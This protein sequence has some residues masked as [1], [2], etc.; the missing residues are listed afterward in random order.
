MGLYL[1]IVAYRS[2]VA[3]VLS[4]IWQLELEPDYLMEAF[5]QALI[6]LAP[7]PGSWASRGDLCNLT[8]AYGFPMQFPDPRWTSMA[9]K[10]RVVS[11]VAS[12]CRE[13]RRELEYLPLE[14]GRRPFPSWYA[15]SYFKVLADTLDKAEQAGIS[16]RFI[17]KEVATSKSKPSFQG[18]AERLINTKFADV[19]FRDSR[20]R[21]KC[22]TWRFD[23]LP[24]RL[25]SRFMR[26][27][28]V[29]LEHCP[30]RVW[31]VFFRTIW[32][33]WVTHER[34]KALLPA[35]PCLLGC[36]WPDDGLGHYVC[37][38]VY[39]QFLC[40]D[41]PRGLGIRGLRRTK[42]NAMLLCC[43]LDDED[44]VRLA[45]GLYALHRTVNALR[46]G[47]DGALKDPTILLRMFAKH[48]VDFSTGSKLLRVG[49]LAERW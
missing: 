41:R 1:N 18:V 45:V 10:L 33:G 13:R 5:Q 12:D 25:E 40:K 29:I 21:A 14:V 38:S 43:G 39:W 28:R 46:F 37:C 20:I 22:A 48:A 2:F 31:S 3:S 4:Y 7:G 34:M 30:P 36:G 24:G 16:L 17:A 8:G 26:C 15:R 11:A 23:I 9:A 44:V 42:E 35:R 19:Y 32:N 27:S 49:L 47:A 6:K